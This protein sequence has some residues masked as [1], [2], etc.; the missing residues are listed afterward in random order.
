MDARV[1]EVGVRDGVGPIEVLDPVLEVLSTGD[2]NRHIDNY[3][4]LRTSASVPRNTRTTREAHELGMAKERTL[5]RVQV[6]YDA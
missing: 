1:L 2:E 3:G 4:G 5:R 6:R